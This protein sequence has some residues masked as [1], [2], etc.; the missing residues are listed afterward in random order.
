MVRVILVWAIC[1][2]ACV[3]RFFTEAVLADK[4]P[5]NGSKV[6][7][8]DKKH[9]PDSLAASQFQV[10]EIDHR[11]QQ[12]KDT[13]N[14][15][16]SKGYEGDYYSSG[17]GGRVQNS[18]GPPTDGYYYEERPPN[19]YR[20]NHQ[21]S[22]D[23]YGYHGPPPF[24]AGGGGGGVGGV[25]G[26]SPEVFELDKQPLVVPLAGIALLGALAVLIGNPLLLHLGAVRRRRAADEDNGVSMTVSM[27]KYLEKLSDKESSNCWMCNVVASVY[28]GQSMCIERSVCEAMSLSSPESTMDKQVLSSMVAEV[29][30]NKYVPAR[31]KS[32][33]ES[34]VLSGRITKSCRQYTCGEM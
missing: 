29:L 25:Y 33:L 8:D 15:V 21:Q 26:D 30:K 1:L 28:D 3:P 14:R 27:T 13:G 19:H 6:V 11:Q 22:S 31:F 5:K 10:N 17:G 34:A 16:S 20:P 18:Y 7:F 32:R 24:A 4:S 23:N 12:H 9:V 2:G